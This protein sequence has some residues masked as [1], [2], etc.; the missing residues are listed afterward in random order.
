VV[1][2][3]TANSVVSIE[4]DDPLPRTITEK[5]DT[6]V[7]QIWTRFPYPNAGS[8]NGLWVLNAALLDN[9][10]GSG[11]DLD[12]FPVTNGRVTFGFGPNEFARQEC[13]D[14]SCGNLYGALRGLH[15]GLDFGANDGN[16][17]IWAGSGEGKVVNMYSSDAKPNI[18]IEFNGSYFLHG[19]LA[20]RFVQVGDRVKSGQMIGLSG[21][22]HLHLGVRRGDSTFYNP[23]DHFSRAWQSRLAPNM[24]P[25]PY[26]YTPY[27][28]VS[29]D[30][31]V[32]D[33]FWGADGDRVTG[34]VWRDR[35]QNP[36]PSVCRGQ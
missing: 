29:F 5:P 19:H 26:N 16:I 3:L 23:L 22:G 9:C 2:Y 27:S 31:A 35:P 14:G 4:S 15:N 12:C 20:R 32:G 28:M 13:E 11:G 7:R 21:E 24:K 18:V 6:A 33:W 1:G 36:S 30:R 10:G 34:I 25:Y 8:A 17:V